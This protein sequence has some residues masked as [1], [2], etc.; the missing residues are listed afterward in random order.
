MAKNVYTIPASAPF[1]EAL[2]RGLIW[3]HG[4]EPFALAD[5]T[6]LLPTRRAARSFGD[7]FSRVLGGA[8]LLPQF[9]PLG[10]VDEEEMLFEGDELDLKPA[11]TPI[12]R[13]LLLTT[14]IRR[15]R[16]ELSLSQAS[17]LADSLA[18]VMDELET[19]NARFETLAKEIPAAL[20]K[21][22]SDVHE[23]LNLL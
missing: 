5:T 18:H 12:R 14:M 4:P 8:A 17:A 20:G 19:Q 1:A 13:R 15:W 21:H 22:W 7:A 2:A 6:I 3:R 11:I 10:D 16:D 9:K 23:F